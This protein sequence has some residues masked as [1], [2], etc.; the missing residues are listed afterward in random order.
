MGM[1]KLLA[2]IR[3][4]GT[5][6]A[7]VQVLSLDEYAFVSMPAEYFV[8]LGLRIKQ[9]AYPRRALVVSCAN[10][11]VGYVPHREAFPRG[12]YET[13]FISSSRI[14]PGA[15]ELLADGAI[16]LIRGK[17]VGPT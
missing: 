13:T 16:D 4:R 10:G 9:G 15:G 5:Q 3:E 2:R 17:E 6:P 14:G 12:G 11:M 8:Q 7:E 1:P